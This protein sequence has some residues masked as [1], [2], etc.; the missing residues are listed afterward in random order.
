MI[1]V[2]AYETIDRFIKFIH[3]NSAYVDVW[4]DGFGYSDNFEDTLLDLLANCNKIKNVDYSKFIVYIML[5]KFCPNIYIPMLPYISFPDTLKT[6]HPQN[7]IIPLM[8]YKK[9]ITIDMET[10]NLEIH[11]YHSVVVE[12][13]LIANTFLNLVIEQEY[14][15][16]PQLVFVNSFVYYLC[17]LF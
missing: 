17:L 2:S 3:Y 9:R 8:Y 15:Y 5:S 11:S 6:N 4:S 1:I 16:I 14:K 7:L 10:S 12:N 13:N